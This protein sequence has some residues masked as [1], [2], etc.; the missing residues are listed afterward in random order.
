MALPKLLVLHSAYREL[1]EPLLAYLKQLALAEPAR[2]VVV[3]IPELVERRWYQYFLHGQTASLLKTLLL[4][5][6]IPQ[7]VIVTTPWYLKDWLPERNR[8][9]RRRNRSRA[10]AN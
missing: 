5:R 2:P 8:L 7:L 4:L 1:L 6:G 9:F 10:P 3:V